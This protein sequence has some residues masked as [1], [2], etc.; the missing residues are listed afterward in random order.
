[1]IR[2]NSLIKKDLIYEGLI[3]TV[4]MDTT[5][6]MLR[7]WSGAGNKFLVTEKPQKITLNFTNNLDE[8]EL[9]NLVKLINNLG[10]FI[11]AVLIL[12]SDVKWEK[13]DLENF[14]RK[15]LDKRLMSFQLEAKYDIEANIYDFDIL[16][17][18][19]PFIY[20]EKILKYGLF[21][22]SKEKII[23][24]PERIY[25]VDNESDAGQIAF[26]FER[27]KNKMEFTLFR[28]NFKGVRKDNPSIRLFYDPNF[29][30]ALYTLSNIHP[31]FIE[32]MGVMEI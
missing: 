28:I 6:D 18:V 14:I 8:K 29:K 20:K 12:K 27:L 32:D 3:H 10:W 15:D 24:H 9:R 4:D 5:S 31:R 23:K 21:P 30:D 25:F 7:K 2:L 16:F 22:K 13:F 17:H 19:S 11:S 1:M 26:Q